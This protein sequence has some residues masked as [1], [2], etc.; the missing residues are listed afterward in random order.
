[1]RNIN[2]AAATADPTR[3]G[4]TPARA[5]AN[6]RARLPPRAD[7][8]KDHAIRNDASRN[9]KRSSIALCRCL[10]HE[11]ARPAAAECLEC[12]ACHP[13]PF[14][15]RLAAKLDLLRAVETAWGPAAGWAWGP[16]E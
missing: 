2:P 4:Q 12:P 11:P 1:M 5:K 14:R 6:G 8:V 15:Y 9:S 16:A 7:A 13:A 10:N 3:H